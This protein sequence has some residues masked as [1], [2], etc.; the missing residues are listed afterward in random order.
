MLEFEKTPQTHTAYSTSAMAIEHSRN[1]VIERSRSM[2]TRDHSNGVSSKNQRSRGSFKPFVLFVFIILFGFCATAQNGSI[3]GSSNVLRIDD[4][5]DSFLHASWTKDGTEVSTNIIYSFT[6]T[7]NVDLVAHFEEEGVGIVETQGI[8]S[9]QVY[10]NPT[11]GELTIEISDYQISDF[12]Y[13]IS[14]IRLFDVMG[15]Q[16]SIVGQ[17]QIGQSQIIIN[18]A[19][20]PNGVYFL[21]IHTDEGVVV[22]KVVKN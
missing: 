17:S 8:A 3:F 22:R 4:S 10:P 11:S 15:R 21:C 6:A 12:R 19:H 16:I 20:L 18:V 5:F 14:D 2:E 1:M 13:P 9:L 7:E